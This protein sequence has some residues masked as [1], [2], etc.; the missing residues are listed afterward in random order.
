MADL[1]ISK[2]KVKEASKEC[3]VASEYYEALDK[4]VINIIKESE[5]R[6]KANGRKTIR[7]CDI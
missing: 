6:A 5:A 7:A 4:H 1:I 3:N 2:S